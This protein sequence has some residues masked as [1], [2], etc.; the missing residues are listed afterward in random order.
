[1]AKKKSSLESVSIDPDMPL[2]PGRTAT[3]SA[4]QAEGRAMVK[5]ETN[6]ETWMGQ[7]SN[8]AGGARVSKIIE[9][10]HTD[11]TVTFSEDGKEYAQGTFT[12]E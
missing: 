10:G 9:T 5:I 8:S 12:V 1:M 4:R 2:L 3:F 7:P 6:R 11:I